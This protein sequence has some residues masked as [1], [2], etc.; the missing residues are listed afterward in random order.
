MAE[1]ITAV[2][3]LLGAVYVYQRERRSESVRDYMI[4]R[5]VR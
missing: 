3:C 1:I 2:I 4:R 5:M